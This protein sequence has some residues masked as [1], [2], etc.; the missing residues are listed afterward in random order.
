[1]QNTEDLNAILSDIRTALMRDEGEARTGSQIHQIILDAAPGIDIRSLVEIP[2]GPGALTKFIET[3][4]H[5]HINRIGMQGGDVL[6]GVGDGVVPPSQT[7]DTS[8]WKAFVSPNAVNSLYLRTSDMKLVVAEDSD[9]DGANVY[10]ARVTNDEHG[11][12]RQEFRT[13]LNEDQRVKL[14]EQVDPDASYDDFVVALRAVGLMKSWGVFR[15]DAFKDLLAE[16]LRLIPVEDEVISDVTNQL[17]KSQKANFSN[18]T[19]KPLP[20]QKLSAGRSPVPVNSGGLNNLD[21]ARFLARSV[22]DNMGYDELR[23]IHVPF[24][25]VLDALNSSK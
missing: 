2:T 21:S 3:Y 16:R 19:G 15:R 7:T 10:I 17:M 14:D 24:G 25:A 22:I 9:S 23:A 12:I 5:Q 11:R 4:L 13:R 20:T 8:I 1:M 6:Y 18:V